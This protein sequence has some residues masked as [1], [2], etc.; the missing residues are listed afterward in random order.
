MSFAG[1]KSQRPRPKKP[2]GYAELLPVVLRRT[3]PKKPGSSNVS[4]LSPTRLQERQRQMAEASKAKAKAKALRL[5]STNSI[6]LGC[7]KLQRLHATWMK[8]DETR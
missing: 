4:S 1:K 3:G 5:H 7:A 6:H 8:W 2:S